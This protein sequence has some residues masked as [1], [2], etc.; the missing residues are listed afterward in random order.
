MR[1]LLSL[2][3]ALSAIVL[4][5]GCSS[6]KQ[7]VEP[8]KPQTTHLSNHDKYI[9]HNPFKL[10][11]KQKALIEEA[12]TW[13]GTP[14]KYAGDVKHKGTDCSGFTMKVYQNALDVAIPRNSAKQA[15]FC[16]HVDKKKLQPGDLV[17]FAT[18]KS[19]SKVSHVG[20]MLTDEEFI[21]ASSSKGVVISRLDSPY[22]TRTYI[23][24]GRVKHE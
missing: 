21:H 1:K 13:L 15:E 2:I 5:T 18:G 12:L 7:N 22:Y 3:I 17:F 10:D 20:M 19:S 16:K 8:E 6:H 9:K 4:I 14:Y 23:S 11:K 24:G